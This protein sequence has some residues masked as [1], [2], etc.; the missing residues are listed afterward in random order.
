MIRLNDIIDKVAAY[1]E[2][3]DNELD[4]IKKAYIYSAKVHAG[5]T[6]ISGEA[7]LSHP[8]EVSAI[9]ADLKLDISTISTGLLH[10]TVEDTLATIQEIDDL[11]GKD[12]AFLVDGTT[13]ISKLEYVS[14][15]ESQAESFRKFILATAKDI[16]VVLIKLA[17][18]L[19]N[20][21]TL[22][23]LPEDRRIR[24]SQETMDI[25]APLAH[26]LGI[27]W[28][29]TE[30]ED[31][32]FQFSNPKDYRKVTKLVSSKKKEWRNY[33]NEVKNTISSKLNELNI[34]ADVTGRFK[35][36]YGIYKK[37][38]FQSKD[39]E[40]VYDILA[41]RVLTNSENECYQTLGAVHTIWKPI[42]GRFK[43]Y[44]ALP[45][46]NGYQS[47]HTTVLGPLGEQVEIQIRTKDMH[48]YAEYGVA[49]HWN[50][51]EQNVNG[52]GSYEMYSMLRKLVEHKDIE[53]P[54]EFLDAI[55]GELISNLLY[56]FTPGGDLIELQ[57][58]ATPVDFAYAIHSDIGDH[59]S[60]AMV[61]R[62]LVSLDYKLKTG[63]TVE[64]TINKEQKPNRDWLSFVVTSKAKTKIRSWL[65]T[66]ENKKAEEIGKSIAERKLR[67][68]GININD[69]FK[70]DKLTEIFEKFELNNLE[71]LYRAVGFGNISINDLIKFVKPETELHTADKAYRIDK[72]IKNIRKD[73][74]KDAVLVK[75]F[76][77][78]MTRFAK[79]CSP[80]PGESISG[81]ITRGKGITI[82]KNDCPHLLE[83]DPQRKIEVEWDQKFTEQMPAKIFVECIDKPGILSKLTKTIS[84][85]DVNILRVE[86]DSIEIEKAKGVF[87]LTVDNVNQLIAVIESLKKVKGVLS[88]D[89]I[90]D[91]S[92][93]I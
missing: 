17:D 51:K 32:A 6:R 37:M 63:D 13:K 29:N 47:L 30:L 88:V 56:V 60:R 10:D 4:L 83:V 22:K 19:H 48:E 28:I 85:S 20:M 49:A 93:E 59:C 77:D 43:D 79:C 46:T 76:N 14:K 23:Y 50:Y 57:R 82:H 15:L 36:N 64:I 55:K 78:I 84:S 70:K 91:E 33:L 25:Y 71:E 21:R 12:I 35:H 2:I 41:F 54:A 16:R 62:A 8:L 53:D 92:Q 52:N 58:G 24:I 73:E 38:Q 81:Y 65:R 39:F 69:I 1:K 11:F 66:L 74:M 3:S 42:P 34:D 68:K 44:I 31:L 67:D 87:N 5:Q 7:Y 40:K 86:M 80:L 26:R 72:I 90:F 45:K 27:N 89:R 18:R 61:N 9:L 75:G